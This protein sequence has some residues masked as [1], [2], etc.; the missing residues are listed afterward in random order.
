MLRA[1]GLPWPAKALGKRSRDAR[2]NLEFMVSSED[3]GVQRPLYE[4][5]D[6]GHSGAFLKFS[7]SLSV[8]WLCL[9]FLSCWSG[10][11][12]LCNGLGL[13]RSF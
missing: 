1:E 11:L 8:A 9:S 2:G 4:R 7:D 12:S 13:P 5:D 6:D 10:V 3:M